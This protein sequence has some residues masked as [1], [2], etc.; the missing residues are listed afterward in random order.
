MTKIETILHRKGPLLSGELSK[1]MQAV[2]GLSEVTIRKQISRAADPVKK[3]SG[4]FIYNQSLFFLDEHISDGSYIKVLKDILKNSAKRFFAVIKALEYHNGYM[5]ESQIAAYTFSPLENL[6]GHKRSDMVLKEVARTGLIA[7]EPGYLKLNEAYFPKFRINFKRY[8]AVETARNFVLSQFRDWARKIGMVSYET[9]TL[10]SEF[11]KFQWAFTAPSYI[12][13]LVIYKGGLNNPAFVLADILI[14][15]QVKEDNVLF[16]VEKVGIVKS[17]YLN[18]RIIPFLIVD[19]INAGAL[20][21]LKQQGIIVGFIDKLFGYGYK[22]L[23]RD[24]ISTVTNAAA[25]LK[26]NPDQ[27]LRL[28]STISKLTDGKTNN[29]RGDIFEMAVGY[30]HSR[31][32]RNLDISKIIYIDGI[33]RELDVF[34]VYPH[35]VTVCECKGL[36]RA[37]TLGEV[38]EWLKDIILLREWIDMQDA[39]RGKRHVFELWSTDGFTPDAVIK[40]ESV[41]AAKRYDIC[42][43]DQPAILKKAREIPGTKFVKILQDYFIQEPL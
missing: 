8:K 12:S 41:S 28:M 35:Q 13:S 6:K 20:Q 26:K 25:I 16:F 23:I 9:P 33:Q 40:L 19:N 15:S 18:S 14:G 10:F 22:E 17:V 30:Y 31:L 38:D 24:L 34:A 4:F 5:A 32:C 29:L 11:S 43:F 1:A 3:L 42:C 37:L 7:R 39:Y 36:K 21:I 2:S 27:F